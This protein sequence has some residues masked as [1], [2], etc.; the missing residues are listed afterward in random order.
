MNADGSE[1]SIPDTFQG[2]PILDL[3]FHPS[4]ADRVHA[5]FLMAEQ[6]R[7]ES[8]EGTSAARKIPTSAVVSRR[9]G[10]S[11]IERDAGTIVLDAF[12]AAAPDV[13]ARGSAR[14][15]PDAAYKQQLHDCGV[16]ISNDEQLSLA[17]ANVSVEAVRSLREAY[18]EAALLTLIAVCRMGVLA[19]MVALK[20]T[21]AALSAQQALESLFNAQ[22]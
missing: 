3:N 20:S 8:S 7:G 5:Q 19:E 15:E 12:P 1:W 6:R 16:D 14:F 21:D 9:E 13:G 11:V 10:E 17:L 22:Q 4:G 2:H 18:P